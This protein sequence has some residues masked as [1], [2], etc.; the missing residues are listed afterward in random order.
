[1]GDIEI[2]RSTC[3][4]DRT[5]GRAASRGVHKHKVASISRVQGHEVETLIAG[6]AGPHECRNQFAWTAIL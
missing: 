2:K 6:P 4:E 1:M 3:T 5:M